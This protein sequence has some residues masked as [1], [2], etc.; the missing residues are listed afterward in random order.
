MEIVRDGYVLNLVFMMRA[1]IRENQR[2]LS[3]LRSV[4]GGRFASGQNVSLHEVNG[5]DRKFGNHF[6]EGI[7]TS[8]GTLENLCSKGPSRWS[9]LGKLER[10]LKE[11]KVDEAWE[12]Y[13]NFERDYGFPDRLLVVNLIT[14]SSY[15]SDS[16]C[17]RMA[18]GLV[19]K[20]SKE[21]P[22]LL[23]P[24]LMTKLVL[25][26]ARAQILVPAARVLRVMLE[27]KTLPSL[28]ML[29]MVFLHLVKTGTGSYLASNILEEICSC[30][31][32]LNANRSTQVELTRP[33]VTVFN[34][35]LAACVRFGASLKGQQIMELMPVVGVAA[36]AHTAVIIARIHEMN[37]TR[38]ELK[39][40]KDCVDM[41][42]VSLVHHYL[43]FY[44]CVLNLHFKFNDID[45]AS[46]LLLDLSQYSEPN[47]LQRAQKDQER[48]C[49]VSIGS[50]NIKMGL[51]L[52]FLPQQ[53]QKDF[54]YK[55]DHKQELLLHKKGKFVL[56]NKGLAKIIIGYKSSGRIHELS[57]FLISIQ[58]M[59][60]SQDK[61]SPY[62]QV[63]D[64]CIYMGW[65]ET[66]HDILE[67]LQ[68]E[69]YCVR[70]G[71]Y[72]SLLTAYYNKKMLREAEGLVRQIRKLGLA[73]NFSDER[74]S[75]HDS[76]SED[77]KISDLANSIIQTM[78]EDDKAVP[79]L[80]HQLN[81]SI[82]FFSKAKMIEDA[83]QTYR[84][85]QKMKIQPNAS[86]FFYLTC[87]YSSEGMY[88]E[89]TVLW[90]DIKRSMENQNTVYTR[91][92]YELLLLSFIRGGYFERVM[93]VIH[94]MM[95]NGMFLDKWCYKTEFLKLHRNLYRT[96]TAA[97][98]KDEAQSR[99]FE[100]V[101]AFR[102]WVGIS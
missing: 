39:K 12:T 78:R 53:L 38:D 93:E 98:A 82:F 102:K 14:E 27:K 60:N 28:D 64:A 11:H 26:L 70:E 22:V 40:F 42:P 43:Q 13:K 21:R 65:L 72:S 74:L 46:T 7:S 17:L 34:L 49:T 5:Y 59:M 25:S 100:Y 36:D 56:S 15:S 41:V 29:Q 91:E 81:S 19:L 68:A 97:D 32:E 96:L 18:S 6:L 88:R 84:K 61:S 62:S 57:K 90:G 35:V 67:D 52:Q 80:V 10:D 69:N 75:S 16:K 2:G 92:L 76:D 1:L 31:K 58:N 83:R 94:F 48:S 47:P 4:L 63:I 73:I 101:K 89:I 77:K 8:G 86:T 55:G 45:G 30:S 37:A 24:K 79:F 51:K 66:A 9:L 44:D 50:D 99:R 71:S 23:T 20:L 33:D 85:M 87:G 3:L 54:V 95:Q